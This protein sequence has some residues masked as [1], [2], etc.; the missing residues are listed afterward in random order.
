MLELP[1]PVGFVLGGGGSLGASQVGML[2]ALAEHGVTPDLVTGTSVGSLN[3][4]VLARAGE[5]PVERLSA[6]WTSMTRRA[7]FPGGPLAQAVTLRKSRTHLFTSVGLGALVDEVLGSD[8]TFDDC[9]IPLGVVAM[10]VATTQA[11]L[12]REGPLKPAVLASAAIPGIYPPV[13][14]GDGLYYDG[15]VVAN[16][17]MRQAVAMGA[18][19]LVVLDCA[20]PSRLPAAPR[21]I[22]EVVFMVAMVAMRQQAVL[23]A[24]A[25]AAELPVVYL[26][27]PPLI[28]VSPLDFTH[29]A[30]L[31]GEA[32]VAAS[33]FLHDLR[34][35][36]PGLYQ[37]AGAT[38]ND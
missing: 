4:A 21:T 5:I 15:G 23:E 30:E 34:V 38:V 10:D 18:K 26:P 9:A 12:L 36:G 1:R 20:F 16:V 37:Q 2:R 8:T 31:L 7:V 11:V 3:G 24:P 6:I 19:S 35:S 14:L 13:E 32:Y 33:A 22:A 17:P 25:I 27:G 29:T 28:R